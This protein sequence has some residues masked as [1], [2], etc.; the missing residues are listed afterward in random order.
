MT[1]I[2]VGSKIGEAS[3]SSYFLKKVRRGGITPL[4]FFILR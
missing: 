2:N 4:L 3:A 1:D